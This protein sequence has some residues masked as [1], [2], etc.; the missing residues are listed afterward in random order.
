MTANHSA[1]TK[2]SSWA[3]KKTQKCLFN[4]PILLLTKLVNSRCSVRILDSK[5][6]PKNK[7]RS[8]FLYVIG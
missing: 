8:D 1:L 2:L 6:V 3:S 7:Y 4:T 5:V